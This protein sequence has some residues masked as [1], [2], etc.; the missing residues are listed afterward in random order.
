MTCGLFHRLE[1]ILQSELH[2]SRIS[3]APDLTESAA[4]ETRIWVI[5]AQAVSHIEC[6]A[7]QFESLRLAEAELS[8]QRHVEL[9]GA[10]AENTAPSDSTRLTPRRLPERRRIEVV[11]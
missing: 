4:L 3:S 8:G 2:D 5:H 6:L 10:G 1:E 11:L 9:P 7:S